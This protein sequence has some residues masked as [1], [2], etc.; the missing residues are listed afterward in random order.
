MSSR[1][2]TASVSINLASAW[3]SP[4]P[5]SAGGGSPRR[6][7][8][9]IVVPRA[10]DFLL[11]RDLTV[12]FFV[13]GQDAAQPSARS[14]LRA[15]A[16][17]GH[18]IANH[19][20]SHD[21]WLHCAAPDRI[22]AGLTEAHQAIAE[23]AGVKPVGFRAPGLCCSPDLLRALAGMGYEYDSSILPT[24]LVRSVLR[25][26]GVSC[27]RSR[28]GNRPRVL[29]PCGPRNAFLPLAPYV[30]RGAASDLVE[31]PVTTLPLLRLPI[32]PRWILY[33]CRSSE[34][35]AA[36]C[37]SAAVELCA[38]TGTSISLLLHSLDFLGADDNVPGSHSFPGM[39]LPSSAKL[40]FLDRI[41]T[42]LC[43]RFEPVTMKRHARMALDAG[44]LA[45]NALARA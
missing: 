15:I 5:T 39:D 13:T 2:L 16:E 35:V 1:R 21:P 3:P 4:K 42:P 36:A 11:Q 17:A 12:T 8:F 44:N 27:G 18:E 28:E 43:M 38:S 40:R 6:P 10:L 37:F 22:R 20:L 24:P 14:T 9:D 31:L 29:R 26:H 34:S 23:A 19:S 32:H 7:H 33:A 41:L 45:V 30:W 25:C